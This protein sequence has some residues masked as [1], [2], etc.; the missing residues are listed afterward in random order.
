ME[1]WDI[2][3]GAVLH[4]LTHRFNNIEQMRFSP[5]GGKLVAVGEPRVAVLWD[6]AAGKELQSITGSDMKSCAFSTDGQHLAIGCAGRINVF[7]AESG[8]LKRE[9]ELSP[10]H[11]MP[12]LAFAPNGR[13]LVAVLGP[14]PIALIDTKLWSVT[15][16]IPNATSGQMLRS[17]S[18]VNDDL[19]VTA[20]DQGFLPLRELDGTVIATAQ[21]GAGSCLHVN[22]S[23]DS[24][25]VATA[26]GWL[27][28]M[29]QK[30]WT[31]TSDFK[32]R[33]WQLPES[34]WQK[35]AKTQPIV[36]TLKKDGRY[37][38]AGRP[39]DDMVELMMRLRSTLEVDSDRQVVVESAEE[40]GIEPVKQLVALIRQLGG[41]Q[42]RWPDWVPQEARSEL[43]P[44]QAKTARI[45]LRFSAPNGATVFEIQGEKVEGREIFD[46]VKALVTLKSDVVF[47][48]ELGEGVNPNSPSHAQALGG[49]Q[50]VVESAGAKLELPALFVATLTRL[51]ESSRREF[52]RSKVMQ[53]IGLAM[54]AYHDNWKQFPPAKAEAKFDVEG[55]PIL[56]WRVHLLP[57]LGH[58]ALHKKFHLDQPWDS[59]HNKALLVEMPDLYKTTME[60]TKTT[61]LAVVGD[62]TVYDGKTGLNITDITDGSSNTA[63]VVDA[64]AERAVPWTKPED[65]TLDN[66]DPIR[67]FG[68]SDF[69]NVFLVLMADERTEA[70]AFETAPEMLR[71]LFM[72][73]D[74][75]VLDLDARRTTPLPM[76]A[77]TSE[78]RT[79][80]LPP[81]IEMVPLRKL[82]GPVNWTPGLTFVG[83][84]QLVLAVSENEWRV[85]DVRSGGRRVDQGGRKGGIRQDRREGSRAGEASR[86]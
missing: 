35:P 5:D 65:L 70:V 23:S 41:K 7:D 1:I 59:P 20:S 72:R 15:K 17:V 24:R 58:A 78:V 4:R 36:V 74:G 71:N 82:V 33:L 27:Y 29:E 10:R 56:S 6:A 39:V 54:H 80:P 60:P 46:R 76:P 14:G 40:Y 21:G 86:R 12:D 30:K 22:V 16:M 19:L 52:Q 31:V 13:Q 25:Q 18:F 69:G 50:R 68:T 66:E 43:Q 67:A 85:W 53:Q 42:I 3:K 44:S 57:Y 32:V 48:L 51:K 8:S 49:V 9:I 26:G 63:L 77:G 55:R 47:Q 79:E 81:V 38:V 28:D 73:A 83:S 2:E 62:G 37:L 61:F 45:A 64:G 75:N 11:T 34:V 84:S